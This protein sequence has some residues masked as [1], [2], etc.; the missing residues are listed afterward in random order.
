MTR[1][2]RA[3]RAEARRRQWTLLLVLLE[4]RLGLFDLATVV[5][6]ADRGLGGVGAGDLLGE[7][8]IQDGTECCG[9]VDLTEREA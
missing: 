6:E 1:S 2:S 8:S 3:R 7:Q 9:H 4:E 5:D